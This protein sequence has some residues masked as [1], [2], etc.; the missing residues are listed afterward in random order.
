MTLDTSTESNTPSARSGSRRPLSLSRRSFTWRAADGA[1][2]SA[3]LLPKVPPDG[4][5]RRQVPLRERSPEQ[6]H[7]ARDVDGPHNGERAEGGD[8]QLVP[9]GDAVD[10]VGAGAVG[11]GDGRGLVNDHVVVGLGDLAGAPVEGVG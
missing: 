4:G 8:R 7:P 3:G 6:A 5:A 2:E 11:N 1:E 9:A 10:G